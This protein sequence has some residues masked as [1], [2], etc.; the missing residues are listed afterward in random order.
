MAEAIL[1]EI[2][3]HAGRISAGQ[4]DVHSDTD[5]AVRDVVEQ[6]GE[7]FRPANDQGELAPSPITKQIFAFIGGS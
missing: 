4:P 3:V 5:S 1:H 7:F 6:V 2:S